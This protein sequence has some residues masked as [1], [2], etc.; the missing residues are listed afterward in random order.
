MPSFS[1]QRVHHEQRVAGDQPVRPAVVVLVEVE[2]I[3]QWQI[4]VRRVEEVA[5]SHGA[6]AVLLSHGLQD[7]PR[8]D[9]LVNVERDGR[10]LERCPLGLSRPNEPR[11]EMRVVFV[12]LLLTLRVRRRGYQPDLRVV[13]PGL[14]LMVVRLDRLLLRAACPPSIGSLAPSFAQ[15]GAPA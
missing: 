12:R 6:V 5:L 14:A 15:S 13:H 3:A 1:Q 10:D 8:L 7:R 9:P 4:L 11:I 2:C